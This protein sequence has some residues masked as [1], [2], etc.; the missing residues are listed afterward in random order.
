[1]L[2]GLQSK[3]TMQTAQLL[4]IVFQQPS[5]YERAPLFRTKYS[6]VNYLAQPFNCKVELDEKSI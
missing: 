6:L 5:D 4:H 2:S 1:M 3:E